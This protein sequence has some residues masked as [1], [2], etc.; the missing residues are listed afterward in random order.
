MIDDETE[1]KS[2]KKLCRNEIFQ[3]TAPSGYKPSEKHPWLKETVNYPPPKGG[4][5]VRLP[6]FSEGG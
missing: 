6:V 2:M 4:E 1:Y 5:L 3:F